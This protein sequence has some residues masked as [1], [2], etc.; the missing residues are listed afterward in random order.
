MDGILVLSGP[1]V[2]HTPE[3]GRA[4]IHDVAPTALYLLNQSIYSEMSGTVRSEYLVG[5]RK[6]TFLSE[7]EDTLLPKRRD[8]GNPYT[9]K[10]LEVVR[11]RLE[12]MGYV[13]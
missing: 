12:S 4:A 10:D 11:R 3:R 6:P 9:M 5:S 1:A 2:A 7:A 13:H 8:A